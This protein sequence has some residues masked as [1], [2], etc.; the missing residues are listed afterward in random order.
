M[1]LLVKNIIGSTNILKSF[2]SDLQMLHPK[3]ASVKYSVLTK[4]ILNV[5]KKKKTEVGQLEQ[6]F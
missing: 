4:Y 6:M 3:K 5:T 1:V 2:S